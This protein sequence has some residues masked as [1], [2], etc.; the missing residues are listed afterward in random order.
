[1]KEKK[2]MVVLSPFGEFL[3]PSLKIYLKNFLKKKN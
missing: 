2:I 1:M 3:P